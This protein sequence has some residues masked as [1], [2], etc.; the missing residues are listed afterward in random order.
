MKIHWTDRPLVSRYISEQV[1]WQNENV[2]TTEEPAYKSLCSEMHP[3]LNA[4]ANQYKMI[5]LDAFNL[6]TDQNQLI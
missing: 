4:R 1:N 5:E 2:D 6:P 3:A